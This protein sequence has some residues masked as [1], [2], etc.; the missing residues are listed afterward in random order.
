LTGPSEKRGVKIGRG[1]RQGCCLSQIPLNLVSEYLTEEV[2][3]GFG[4][5]R[6]GGQVTLAV[7]YADDLVL[8]ANGETLL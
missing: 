5:F 8:L 4:D 6:L 1:F 2:L 3:E 7:E